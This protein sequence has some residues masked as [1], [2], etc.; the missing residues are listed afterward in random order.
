MNELVLEAELHLYRKKTPNNV[1]PLTPASPYYLVSAWHDQRQS[2]NVCESGDVRTDVA[3]DMPILIYAQIRVYQV[4]DDRSLDVPNLHR[5]LNVRYVGAHASGWQVSVWR[6][7]SFAFFR[8][9][10]INI[11]DNF[12]KTIFSSSN[13]I[14]FDFRE[15]LRRTQI[16]S[17]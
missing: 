13:L 14:L 6:F 7:H 8:N 9:N 5:L 12:F 1:R 2:L 17:N 4:L 11:N 15:C 10:S 16:N 3:F